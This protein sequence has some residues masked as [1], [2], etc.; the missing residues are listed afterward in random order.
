MH[1]INHHFFQVHNSLS[2]DHHHTN[3]N[4]SLSWVSHHYP[5]QISALR[6]DFSSNEV[7]AVFD[8]YCQPTKPI[9]EA[10]SHVNNIYFIDNQVQLRN[11]N[12]S[13]FTVV[14]ASPQRIAL[15]NFFNWIFVNTSHHYVLMGYNNFAFDDHWLIFHFKNMLAEKQ[16]SIFCQNL[17]TADIKSLLKLKRKLVVE[18]KE[19]GADTSNAHNSVFDCHMVIQLII[20][21]ALEL[22]TCLDSCRS[23]ES[24]LCERYNPLLRSNLITKLVAQKLGRQ[25]TLEE[26]FSMSDEELTAFLL[27]RGVKTISI[28][29]CLR[30][31]NNY[32]Q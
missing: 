9:P 12:T 29:A 28:S 1:S 23:I 22:S 13:T 25:T 5:Y 2:S 10:A 26:W 20:A 21:K 30:K 19:C 3:N 27:H 7:V 4:I 15:Q 11:P 31:R 32:R 6:Y 14:D 17:F 16:Y 8:T 24:V 18:A